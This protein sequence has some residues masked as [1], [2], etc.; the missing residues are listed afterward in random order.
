MGAVLLIAERS[1]GRIAAAALR[2]EACK[3]RRIQRLWNP[4]GVHYVTV[5]AIVQVTYNVY[6]VK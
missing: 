1:T 5:S 4:G 3:L 2:R 6:Y